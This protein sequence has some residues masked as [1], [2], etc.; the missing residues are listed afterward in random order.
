MRV[1]SPANLSWVS[2]RM[3][4]LVTLGAVGSLAFVGILLAVLLTGSNCTFDPPPGDM[5]TMT[6]LNDTDRTV[7]FVA[8]DNDTCSRHS[9]V[10]GGD[11]LR[12]GEADPSWTHEACS[13]E[14]V[15]VL[16]QRGVLLGCIVL[17][18]AD[19]PKITTWRVSQRVACAGSTTG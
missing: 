9:Q 7:Q 2:K 12:P 6:L 4:V 15:G 17:P 11:T 13:R 19:P 5:A 10:E 1:S 16:D 18:V 3:I 8:C 14:P